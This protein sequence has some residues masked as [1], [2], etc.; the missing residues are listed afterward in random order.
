M[1]VK[2]YGSPPNPLSSEASWARP[3]PWSSAGWMPQAKEYE[4]SLSSLFLTCRVLLRGHI[5]KG[6]W[7][8]R[9]GCS[10]RQVLVMCLQ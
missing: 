2:V 6:N 5:H 7:V 8:D 1:L 9:P 4:P 3:I 10:V